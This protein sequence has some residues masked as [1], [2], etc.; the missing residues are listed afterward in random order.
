MET[1]VSNAKTFDDSHWE[2]LGK[3]HGVYYG[4]NF[5][6]LR[7]DYQGASDVEQYVSNR[8]NARRQYYR[9]DSTGTMID[10]I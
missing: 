7:S 4:D 1:N 6:K 10:I 9:Y 8:I 3:Y 5:N 2:A